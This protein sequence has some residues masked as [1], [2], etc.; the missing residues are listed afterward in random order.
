MATGSEVGLGVEVA[1]TLTTEGYDV[2]L[3]SAM[4]RSTYL[5]DPNATTVSLEAGS[6]MGWKGLV[7][8][9]IGID[10]FGTCGPGDEVMARHGFTVPA[11][12]A[13]IREHLRYL[14]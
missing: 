9:A 1:K 11:V 4:D 8:L 2:R 3:V 5:A 14:R 12:V 10:E 6:T 7:D 13:R